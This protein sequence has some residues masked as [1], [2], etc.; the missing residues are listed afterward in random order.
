MLRSTSFTHLALVVATACICHVLASTSSQDF[1]DGRIVGG[2]TAKAD[3][4]PY[5]V[6]LRRRL[7]IWNSTINDKV[8]IYK[9]SCGGSILNERW[10]VTSA[11]CTQLPI[12]TRNL[13]AV[14]AAPHVDSHGIRYPLDKIISYPGYV[15]KLSRFRNDIGLLRTRYSIK[16]SPKLQPIAISREYITGGLSAIITGWGRNE[17]S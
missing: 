4:F 13:I 3:E 6:S 7:V 5:Q 15:E 11:H 14:G 17:V 16:F 9:H 1:L 8:A 12:T 2:E 10:I